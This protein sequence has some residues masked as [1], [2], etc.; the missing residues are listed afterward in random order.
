MIQV[1]LG[2]QLFPARFYDDG[3]DTIFMC[4]DIELC[5]HFKYHKHK[6]V[7]FLASMRRYREELK[8]RGKKVNYF[9]LEDD[10]HF[11]K[12]LKACLKESKTK[13]IRMVRAED[14]FFR[15]KIQ[16]FC[17]KEGAELEEIE[18]PMFIVSRDEFSDY[19]QYHSRPFMKTFYEGQRK[20]RG[21][22]MNKSGGPE[23]G[24]YSFDS[25]NRK[26]L[27]KGHHI[28][29]AS[30]PDRDNEIT[31]KVQTLVEKV[32]PEHPGSCD[33]F[34]LCTNRRSALMWLDAFIKERLERFGDYQD[35]LDE[36]D[37]FLYHSVISPYL[38]NGM[39]LPQEVIE[40][41]ASSDA[42]LNSKEGLIRQVLG[43]REF[44]RG[45]YLNFESEME[46]RN[47][48]NHKRKLTKDWYEGTTGLL[49]LD[50]AIKKAKEYGYCHHIE[51]L[52]VISNAML[53]CEID[54]KE[55]YKWFM[56]L[57]VDSADW[58]MMGNVYGMGQ[59][60]EG[61]IFAT[62]PYISS[63][64]YLNKMGHFQKGEWQ[65]IWDGLFWNFVK[66]NQKFLEKNYRMNMM[67]KTYEKMDLGKKRDLLAK[68]REFIESKTKK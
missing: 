3:P 50:S 35:A 44:M 34:W 60:S 48:F 57:F 43:W 45:I 19:L 51:R 31:K 11:F 40:K 64:N 4:E 12:K 9:E 7:F 38:N 56:E 66:N 54:P 30:L 55:V 46:E 13:K 61:G 27:P 42:P 63:S 49:P 29:R 37:P 5:R 6:L 41:V 33:N 10:S 68:A 23:G 14:R 21:V 16:A 2:D 58:V 53:L 17:K 47:F 18:S 52:M 26:K 28:E 22:L 67:V 62:K 1:I 36:R 32:F 15:E 65:E 24:K 59:F 8:E 20:K 39:I 25:S